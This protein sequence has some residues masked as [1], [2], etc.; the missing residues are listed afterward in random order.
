YAL[1]EPRFE[2][3]AIASVAGNIGLARTTDNALRLA[4]VVGAEVP[5][6]QGAAQPVEGAG[7]HEEAIHGADGLGGVTL[8]AP[9][10]SP[11]PEAVARLAALLNAEPAG[12]VTILALA[13]LTNLAL[14]ARDHQAAFG[15]LRSEEH[16]S[17][18]QSRENLVCRLLL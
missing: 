1:R 6:W 3:A 12:S 4:A 13:P 16:T 17:E 5:V 10:A 11:L 9:L 2:V 15:R 18:L 7:R 14:L 8:P